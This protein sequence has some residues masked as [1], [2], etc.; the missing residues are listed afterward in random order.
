MTVISKNEI[1]PLKQLVLTVDRN[2]FTAI[3]NNIDVTGHFEKR[4]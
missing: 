2:A 4:F 1:E 3:R